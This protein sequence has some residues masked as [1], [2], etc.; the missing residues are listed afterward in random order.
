MSNLPD[1]GKTTS[2]SNTKSFAPK[3]NSAPEVGLEPTGASATVELYE[4]SDGSVSLPMRVEDDTVWATQAQM[5]ELFGTSRRNVG[6][7][8]DNAYRE[9]ELDESTRKDFFQV[10]QEGAREVKR[11]V[12]HYDLDAI[13][14]VGY[15]VHSPEG[16]R[17]R[18]WATGVLRQR[19]LD[20]N[21]A[22]L[23]HMDQVTELLATSSDE[24]LAS[25]GR[26]MQR[27]NGDLDRL[28][29]YD[30]GEL[31]TP[32]EAPASTRIAIDDVERIVAELRD[33]YPGDERLGIAKDDSIHGV[34]GQ[35]D[36]T[37]AG[38]ALYPTAQEKAANLLYM[39]VKDH[40][41]GDGNKRTGAALFAYFLDR[42]GIEVEKAIPGN[43]L[44]ALTLIA[45]ASD[46]TKK[47]ETVALIRSL[48]SA[49]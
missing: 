15:R 37:F 44:T 25:I 32:T 46:P 47:D 30:R 29:D 5:A 42:N 16:V 17:F 6:L 19:I 36:Q 31:E 14:S 28:A 4:S 35:I 23:R 20:E 39:V 33:R 7:H 26:I 1:R 27:Y 34:L 2:K 49:D 13:I 18:R 10:R 8:L 11:A 24:Q 43:M 21:A 48:L 38:E 45:A 41:F 22:R 9:Q 3:V 12:A 40:P